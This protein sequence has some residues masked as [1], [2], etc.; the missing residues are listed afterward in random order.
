MNIE[1]MEIMKHTSGRAAGG[2]YCG[3]SPDMQALCANGL[4]EPAGRTSFV[5]DDYFRITDKGRKALA[6]GEG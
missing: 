5:P 6:G 1:Q 3:D 2:L 4:M